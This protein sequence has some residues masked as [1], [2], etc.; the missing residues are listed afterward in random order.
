M[1]STTTATPTPAPA[2]DSPK[3]LKKASKPAAAPVQTVFGC[4]HIKSL[5]AS[6]RQPA[7]EGYTKI[8]G[9]LQKESSLVDRIYKSDGGPAA[10]G[11]V[12]YL[13]LQCPNVAATRGKHHKAHRFC[14]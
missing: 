13:C 10:C 3:L 5:L 12:T 1:A 14:Q 4:A 8:I 11:H 2:N 6:A 7:T 9:A